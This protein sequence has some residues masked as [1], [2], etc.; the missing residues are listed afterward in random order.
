MGNC[1]RKAFVDDTVVTRKM[2]PTGDSTT[3]TQDTD[4]I[5]ELDNLVNRPFSFKKEVSAVDHIYVTVRNIIPKAFLSTEILKFTNTYRIKKNIKC[6]NN[7]IYQVNVLEQKSNG[8]LFLAKIITK[9]KIKKLGESM[10]NILLNNEMRALNQLDNPNVENLLEVHLLPFKNNFKLILVSNYVCPKSLHEIINE[11][12]QQ[13]KRFSDK[14]IGIFAKSL[15]GTLYYLKSQNIIHRNL[16]P[17]NIFFR[18][19]GDFSSLSLRNFYFCSILGRI[20]TATGIFGG[21]WFMPPE[22]LRDLKYD[23]KVDIWSA[24]LILYIMITLEN[25]FS[26]C[27]TRDMMLDKLK[28]KM[29]FKSKEELLKYGINPEVISFCY[30]ML[31]E[32]PG[33]RTT[34]ELLLEEDFIKFIGNEEKKGQNI[35]NQGETIEEDENDE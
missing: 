2:S 34:S 33:L 24:G 3:D 23:Y 27:E 1:D 26:D 4:P 5:E 12:I 16:S 17:E 11:H 35:N 28:H 31:S 8:K 30:K 18:K 13:H 19:K 22:M 10:F 21:L 25:P 14:E 6:E 9:N 15:I 7:I 29:V 20:Q 32:S